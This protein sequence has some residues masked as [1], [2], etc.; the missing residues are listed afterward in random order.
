MRLRQ[1]TIEKVEEGL[2]RNRQ[3]LELAT[4]GMGCFWGP[5]ARFGSMAGVIRTRVGFAGGTMPSPTYRQ[6][7]D[8][9]E[10]I[11]I[12]FDPQQISY[13]EVLKEFWQ[14]HYPNRDNYK[15]RQYISL[16]HYH[17][18]QQ[19][20]IIKKVLPE[21]ESRLGELIE[22]EISS[23]TQFTLAEERHQKYYLKR[24]PKALEQLK[25]LYPDSRFLTDSTFAARLNG[26]VKGFG[27]KDSMLKEIS[28]WSIGE[29]EKA[30][31]TELFAMMKW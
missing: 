24:Y 22:T 10:T 3:R 18:D 4:F 27:T 14:N 11:Q 25:E 6:M 8:H 20:Q 29:D 31:L 30:Y 19:R 9:T 16:L 12:E 5:E 1:M 26:F 17:T 21:M 28:Q 7:A 13:E 15:G 2:H 23:F